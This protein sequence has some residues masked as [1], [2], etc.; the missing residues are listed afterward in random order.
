MEA[1]APDTIAGLLPK[2]LRTAMAALH[3]WGRYASVPSVVAYPRDH[4]ELQELLRACARLGCPVIA[5]GSGCSFGDIFM[6]RTGVVVDLT[7]WNE[8]LDYDPEAGTITAQC[9]ISAGRL[10][11]R[12]LPDNWIPRGLPGT[13]HATLAGLLA[14]NV[15]GKD[16]FRYG[17]FGNGVISLKMLLAGGGIVTV[18]REEHRDLFFAAIGG[19]GLLGITLEATLQLIKIPGTMVEVRR[20]RFG[21]ITELFDQ[22]AAIPD[23]VGMYMAW[24]DGFHAPGRGILTTGTWL[25]RGPDTPPRSLEFVGRNFLGKVPIDVVYPLVRPF[26]CR[27]SMIAVNALTFWGCRLAGDHKVVHF[28]DYYYPHMISFPESSRLLRGGLVG[29]HIVVPDAGAREFM[30]ELH[31]FCRAQGFESWFNGVKRLK[32][33]EFL[34]SFAADG[35]AVTIELPGRVAGAGAFDAFLDGM[36]DLTAANAGKIFLAKDSLLK[37][38]HIRALYPRLQEFLERRNAYDPA[39]LFTSDLSRRLA[40]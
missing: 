24:L 13:S 30:V 18:S 3:G 21:S 29:F 19:L 5:K 7:A 36:V 6:N 37:S 4:P 20:Q 11:H 34:M 2:G 14:N 35:Y 38:W 15:H 23:D 33:D 28:Y 32:A 31:S 8:I 9:G 1:H 16:S 12:T 27:T 26:V 17:N 25:N 39:G 40:L 22:F 10:L